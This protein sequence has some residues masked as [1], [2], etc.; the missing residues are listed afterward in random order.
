ML[1][2]IDNE[3]KSFSVY[4][5]VMKFLDEVTTKFWE[6][7]KDLEKYDY[8]YSVRFEGNRA[9]LKPSLRENQSIILK[10]FDSGIE[11]KKAKIEPIIIDLGEEPIEATLT[12][13]LTHYD[14]LRL[15]AD[16]KTDKIT[17]EFIYQCPLKAVRLTGFPNTMNDN[18]NG[19]HVLE[20][21]C[22]MF[23]SQN[24]R[25]TEP[26]T[27]SFASRVKEQITNLLYVKEI[28]KPQGKFPYA[29]FS[30]KPRLEELEKTSLQLSEDSI[31]EVAFT[32]LTQS[33]ISEIGESYD[34]SLK[35]VRG[36]LADDYSVKYENS[37]RTTVHAKPP[38]EKTVVNLEDTF[39][40]RV[41]YT[42][43]RF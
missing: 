4:N 7:I 13:K 14:M 39:G 9:I 32:D 6:K 16:A 3:F 41:V 12:G 5:K 28:N 29:V 24:M 42:R 25:V 19:F 21:G 34:S 23:G 38:F 20:A 30:R 26:I 8:Q 37:G 18:L 11:S 33:Q 10:L 40:D 15:L 31:I 36:K 27:A 22:S 17:G 43:D 2:K 1:L 35:T